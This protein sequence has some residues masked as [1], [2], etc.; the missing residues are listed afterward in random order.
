MSEVSFKNFFFL[1]YALMV[2]A[3]ETC[4]IYSLLKA[5]NI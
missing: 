1:Y 3:L 4:V 2:N 5:L